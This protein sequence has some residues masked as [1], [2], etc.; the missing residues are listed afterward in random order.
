VG[1]NE[2]ELIN[3]LNTYREESLEF[4]EKYFSALDKIKELEIDLQQS[5]DRERVLRKE[6]ETIMEI[7]YNK[8]DRSDCVDEWNTTAI[9]MSQVADKALEAS[10]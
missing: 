4:K 5:H 3:L 8:W 10:K 2:N 9:K 7:F 1:N 6:L